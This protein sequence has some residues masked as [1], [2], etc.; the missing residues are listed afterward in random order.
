MPKEIGVRVAGALPGKAAMLKISDTQF[1]LFSDFV[2]SCDCFAVAGHK[3]PDGDCISSA[4]VL[5]RILEKFGK[6]CSVLSA[7]PFKRPETK[8][9]EHLFASEYSAPAHSCKKTG[10][11]IV[12]CS[13]RARLG[14]NIEKQTESFDC[15]VIDH[16]K[17]SVH[18]NICGIVDPSAPATACLIQQLY[19]HFFGAPE[20]D[21]AEL[22]FFG[23]STDTGFFRFL[24]T[25]SES[26]FCS[27]GR[28]VK[29]G[30]DPR[31]A[32]EH[33]TGNKPLATR[34]LLS[35]AL[36]RISVHCNG[37]LLVTYETLEDTKRYG[38]EG[39]D[40][41]M[42]YQILMATEN[43]QAA[44]VFR[45]ENE[46]NCTVGFRSRGDCD[47]S[48]IAA[49]YGGGGHKNAAGLSIE[50]TL[51]GVIPMIIAEF[52]SKYLKK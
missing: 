11:F 30:A 49:R 22:L 33:M 13:E 31:L 36:D 7:G 29:A 28:L 16:H 10:L 19:E 50:G 2:H 39:R 48:V 18:K 24:N 35:L 17:T 34:K 4:L 12:D 15:F 9:Y 47:V 41:D 45:Q 1:K 23:L 42:L 14:E 44:A 52:E 8:K 51:T 5:A 43:V 25:E 46:K 27:A 20:K 40:S 21:I 37:A 38:R 3:E 6:P 26:V 32:Y